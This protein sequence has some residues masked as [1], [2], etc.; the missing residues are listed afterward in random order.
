VTLPDTANRSEADWA[1][2]LASM[3][4]DKLQQ[5]PSAVSKGH[6]DDALMQLLAALPQLEQFEATFSQEHFVEF[7]KLAVTSLEKKAQKAVK[8]K[9]SKVRLSPRRRPA[10]HRAAPPRLPPLSAAPQRQRCG[11]AHLVPTTA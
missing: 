10:L 5:L 1:A 3:L 9:A 11:S 4:L 7:T 2:I 6:S 8:R